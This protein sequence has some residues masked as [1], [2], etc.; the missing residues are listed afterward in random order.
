MAEITLKGVRKSYGKTEVVHGVDLD[1]ER[2]ELV[3]IL[4]PS[5]CGKSTLLRMVAGLEGITAGDISIAGK[6][7]NRLEPRQRGCAMVFQNYALY[8]H[9]TVAQNIGYSLKVAGMA[10]TERMAKVEQ[11]AASLGLTEFLDRK[12]GQLSGGQRQRVAM[13]R[14]MIREPK[15]FLYDE[16]LSNLDA[17]LRVAMRVEI[18]KLHQRLGATTLF[19]T[20][21]QVEAMTLADR[22]VVMNKGVVEQVGAP[23]EV[24]GRP[25]T[26]YVAGFI[27]TPGLNMLTGAVDKAASAV[28]LGDGQRLAYDRS[29]WPDAADGPVIAGFRAE[30]VRLLRSDADTAA[31]GAGELDGEFDFAEEMGAAQL[32]HGAVAGETVIA[33]VTGH[34]HFEAGEPMRL[35]VEPK[36]VQL[37]DAAT[38]RRLAER[39]DILLARPRGSRALTP[40]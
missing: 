31:A 35:A 15:V 36:D 2:G 33:H 4:G 21:D 12:P 25:A 9:M 24:Y 3:V 37:F 40:A 39:P 14:A 11:V 26:T 27:G 13:G 8:P 23:A 6:V 7:V 28:V 5:G 22:I 18:R 17:R 32:L 30:A 16:P 34:E 1:I 19:V 29:R 38:G 10:K 20:H